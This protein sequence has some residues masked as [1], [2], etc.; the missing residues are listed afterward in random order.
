M[1]S[2]RRRRQRH[3]KGGPRGQSSSTQLLVAAERDR[4]RFPLVLFLLP[5]QLSP[6]YIYKNGAVRVV[7]VL[8]AEKFPSRII[9]TFPIHCSSLSCCPEGP[10]VAEEEWRVRGEGEGV[11]DGGCV[12]EETSFFVSRKSHHVPETFDWNEKTERG[13]M[14]FF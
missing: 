12:M 6:S 13:R 10:Q 8:L 11:V 7:V 3:W 5:P 14:I 2:R 1:T 9:K 4:K